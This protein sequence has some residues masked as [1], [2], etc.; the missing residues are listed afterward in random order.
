MNIH[1]FVWKLSRDIHKFLFIH[2]LCLSLDKT[3]TT[4]NTKTKTLLVP[5]DRAIV[6]LV[7][8]RIVMHAVVDMN[9]ML[10]NVPKGRDQRS[11]CPRW[12]EQSS[13]VSQKASTV[14]IYYPEGRGNRFACHGELG[15]SPCMY[16]RTRAPTVYP[17]GKEHRAHPLSK[18]R[19]SVRFSLMGWGVLDCV[20]PRV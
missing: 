7:P 6:V 16:Q 14:V 2:S 4:T 19:R 18:D 20:G 1:Y 9:A 12:Q 11:A 13:C 17:G 8:E 3:T 5:G 15:K 10:C